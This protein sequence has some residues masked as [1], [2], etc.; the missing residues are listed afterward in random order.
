MLITQLW[1]CLL[2]KGILERRLP[3]S[4]KRFASFLYAFDLM[5]QRDVR[6]IVETGTARGGE[7]NCIGDGGSTLIWAEWAGHFG[8]VVHSVDIDPKAVSESKAA[9]AASQDHVHVFCG[10]SVPFLENFNKPIDLLYLDSCDFDID[11]PFPSQQH[12]LNE[13]QAAYPMLHSNS[14]V[15]IDDCDL[16]HGGKGKLVIDYLLERNWK[17]V[18]SSYQVILIK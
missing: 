10:D 12:H 8:A 1:E 18:F 6:T 15:M 16:P 4:D 2:Q 3:L 7:S 5:R 13:I 9:S 17:K 14:V 11:D